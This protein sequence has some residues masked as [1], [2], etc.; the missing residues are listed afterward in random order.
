VL[1]WGL[2]ECLILS[3]QAIARQVR[4][5][6]VKRS[7]W[8]E[9]GEEILLT[10]LAKLEPFYGKEFSVFRRTSS[11]AHLLRHWRG[12]LP[13]WWGRW[14]RHHGEQVHASTPCCR[15]CRPLVKVC[16]NRHPTSPSASRS[17]CP[18]FLHPPNLCW[19]RL[20]SL[21][22]CPLER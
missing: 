2:I 20:P 13:L 18:V 21:A 17:L 11:A 9:Y 12:L 5:A 4:S 10:L 15:R 19:K 8:A 16:L 3:R 1:D 22:L 14:L 6:N 7:S